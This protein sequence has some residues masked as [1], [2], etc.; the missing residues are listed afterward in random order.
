MYDHYYSSCQGGAYKR[1]WPGYDRVDGL[2]FIKKNI[3]VNHHSILFK[4]TE[5]RN[6]FFIL[7][8]SEQ[9]KWEQPKCVIF[10]LW[11]LAK[12]LFYFGGSFAKVMTI[13]S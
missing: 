3:T 6:S 5:E 4:V 13:M 1:G 10:W 7:V 11:P 12:H 9:P 2:R 8:G